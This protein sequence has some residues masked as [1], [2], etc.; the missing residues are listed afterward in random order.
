MTRPIL[1]RSRVARVTSEP[2]F[3]RRGWLA[4]RLTPLLNAGLRVL[5]RELLPERD[6]LVLTPTVAPVSEITWFTPMLA[7][8]PSV[9]S[10][11]PVVPSSVLMVLAAWLSDRLTDALKT[12]S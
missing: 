12:G 4:V 2:K 11:T 10:P 1:F 5:L 3:F 9:R 8:V 6:T 7:V